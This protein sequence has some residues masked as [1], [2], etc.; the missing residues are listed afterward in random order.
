MNP[1][2][3]RR[4]SKRRAGLSLMRL[5]AV[6]SVAVLSSCVFGKKDAEPD[7]VSATRSQ[8]I[9]AAGGFICLY[10]EGANPVDLHFLGKAQTD[11]ILCPAFKEDSPP[12]IFRSSIKES[13]DGRSAGFAISMD[14]GARIGVAFK[15]RGRIDVLNPATLE[16]LD[17]VVMEQ[18]RPETAGDPAFVFYLDSIRAFC[19]VDKNGACFAVGKIGDS[20]RWTKRIIWN[21]G[22][23]KR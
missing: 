23:V 1:L 9:A 3:Q 13:L 8:L 22:T 15:V 21:G 18:L 11:F 20:K 16:A 4:R 6:L 19:V 5:A 7:T 14:D 12:L 2:P 10:R 17:S